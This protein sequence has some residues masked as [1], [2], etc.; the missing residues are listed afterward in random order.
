MNMSGILDGKTAVVTGSSRGIG[1]E[2]ALRFAGEGCRVV[3]HGTGLERAAA[4][5]REIEERGGSAVSVAG[6]VARAETAES[7]ARAAV[8][9]FGSLDVF[10][11]N[12]GLVR[13]EPFLEF[14]DDAWRESLDVNYTGAFYGCRAA[15]RAMVQCG[16]GGRIL[17][18]S[19]I[20]ANMGQFGFAAYGSTKAALISL[21]RVMAVE[22]AGHRITANCLVPGPVMNAMLVGV[23][24]EEKLRERQKTVPLG[25]LAE[26][27]EVASLALFLASEQARY[28]TGQTFVVDGGASAAGCYTMEV[29]RRA[30]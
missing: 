24:G 21:T 10:V 30:K 14:S 12:A 11:A 5:A 28:I 26:A 27:E 7:L 1:R 17:T 18:V 13:M 3:V 25:R 19:S 22:L 2:M 16:R 23:Y 9:R 8:E 4:V 29:F 20:G 6:D 15:A